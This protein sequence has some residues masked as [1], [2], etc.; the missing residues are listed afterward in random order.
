MKK[1]IMIAVAVMLSVSAFAQV[2]VSQGGIVTTYE[3]GATINIDSKYVTEV[4]YGNVSI[5]IPKGKKVTI[6]QN[7]AGNIIV[8][9]YD[10]SGV[11]I[12]GKEVQA[13]EGSVYVVNPATKTVVKTPVAQVVAN[14]QQNTAN[15]SVQQNRNNPQ[16]QQNNNQNHQ[17]TALE[18]NFQDVSDYVNEVNSQQAVEDVEKQLS[19]SS[20]R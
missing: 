10:L 2:K 1:V 6:S 14:N 16:T 3:K 7:K 13:E 12:L 19:P 8:S 5:S 17:E 11:K 4:T 9:G 18:D 15:K 20:P